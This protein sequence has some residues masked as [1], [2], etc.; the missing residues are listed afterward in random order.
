MKVLLLAYDLG[1]QGGVGTFNY[2]LAIELSKQGVEVV[3]VSRGDEALCTEVLDGLEICTFP[4]PS[5]PPKDVMFYLINTSRIIDLAKKKRIDII[6]DSSAAIGFLPYLDKIAPIITTVHGSPMLNYL[7]V[8]YSTF[9][10]WLRCRLF[11]ISHRLPTK[12]LT[13]FHKPR[14]SK[15]VFVSKSCLADVLTHTLSKKRNNLLKKSTV[16]YNGLSIERITKIVKDIA[17][18]D[19]YNIIFVGRL[20][21]YKGVDRLIKAFQYVIKEIRDAKLHIVGSGPELPKLISLSKKLGLE[22]NIIFHGWLTRNN[23]LKLMASSRI[24]A[25][26]SLYES[27]GYVIVEAYALGKPVIA[28]R[29]PYSKELVEKFNCGLIVNTFNSK[30]FANTIYDLLSDRNLYKKLSENTQ[31]IARTYFSIEKTAKN[32]IKIYEDV[33]SHP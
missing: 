2:E 5:T 20:M 23:V 12:F 27:F 13:L 6:H 15:L 30:T 28:H 25:H 21:E 11:E 31:K 14:V 33:L 19:S 7:R 8:T 26:P 10:D 32:Y 24:L 16:I 4:S 9:N 3:I 22:H 18:T 1:L 17:N 29:A